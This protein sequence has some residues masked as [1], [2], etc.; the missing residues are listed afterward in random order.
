LIIVPE[1]N[2]YNPFVLNKVNADK[3]K[4]NRTIIRVNSVRHI[5]RD[6]NRIQKKY[7][8]LQAYFD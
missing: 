2:Y 4:K 5:K 6:K 8:A 7:K 1:K 3:S